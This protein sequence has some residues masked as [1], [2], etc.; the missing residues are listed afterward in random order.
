ML[1]AVHIH[2]PCELLVF[3]QFFTITLVLP[4]MISYT[5]SHSIIITKEF[6]WEF[7]PITTRNF[8]LGIRSNYYQEFEGIHGGKSMNCCIR[9]QSSLAICLE[10]LERVREKAREREIDRHKRLINQEKD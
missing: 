9:S 10:L 3:F 6:A 4:D 1:V 8:H 5:T 7:V 2:L